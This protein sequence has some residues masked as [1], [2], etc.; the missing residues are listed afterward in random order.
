MKNFF[1]SML[2]RGGKK[3]MMVFRRDEN[4]IWCRVDTIYLRGILKNAAGRKIVRI[5]EDFIISWVL[6]RAGQDAGQ[7]TAEVRGMT[8]LLDI[9]FSHA[10]INR[11]TGEEIELEIE[12]TVEKKETA[13]IMQ[14]DAENE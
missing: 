6:K 4:V 13:T 1:K 11:N 9:L 5:L 14:E 7:C 10:G 12:K 8:M 3:G 2:R